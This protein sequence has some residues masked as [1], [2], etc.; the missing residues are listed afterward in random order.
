MSSLRNKS[1]LVI[2]LERPANRDVDV[3]ERWR[4]SLPSASVPASKCLFDNDRVARI[5]PLT[6]NDVELGERTVVSKAQG[7]VQPSDL[8]LAAVRLP[9]PHE[10]RLVAKRVH[11]ARH[12]VF[13][14]GSE[15]SLETFVPG[16]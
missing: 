9:A 4:R 5:V 15:M 16:S 1:P 14:L 2:K 11:D 13:V 10:L 6:L 12:I 7:L 8:R 3:L